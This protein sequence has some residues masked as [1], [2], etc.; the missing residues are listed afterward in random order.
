LPTVVGW[1]TLAHVEAPT[2]EPRPSTREVL[3]GATF[4]LVTGLLVA[5]PRYLHGPI[6]GDEGFLAA[7][8][9]RVLRGE[10]PNRDF[11]SLQPPFSFYAVA[12]GFA[13]FEPSLS[14]MRTIGLAL[15]QAVGLA[16]YAFALQFA[17]PAAAALAVAPIAVFGMALQKFVPFAVWFGLLWCSISAACL[18]SAF[19]PDPFPAAASAPTRRLLRVA[20][21]AITATLALLS[22]HDQGFYLCLASAVYLGLEVYA[23]RR[24]NGRAGAP[25]GPGANGRS[26]EDEAAPGANGRSTEDEAAPGANGRSTEDEAAPGANGRSTEDEAAPGANGRSA[27][28]RAAPRAYIL[29]LTWL[30]VLALSS[31][32]PLALWTLSGALAPAFEQLVIFPLKRYAETSALD[33]PRLGSGSPLLPTLFYYAPV[34]AA[35]SL[36]IGALRPA[37]RPEKTGPTSAAFVFAT[38]IVTLFYAQVATRTDLFHLVI[39]LP[40]CLVA[41]AAGF[42]TLQRRLAPMATT[43]TARAATWIP[44]AG[45]SA[46]IA[47]LAAPHFLTPLAPDARPLDLP[48]GGIWLEEFE[49][50]R[51]ERAARFAANR[52]PEEDSVLALPYQPVLNFLL[53]RRSP[54]RWLYLWPGDQTAEDHRELIREAES[55]APGLVVLDQPNRLRESAPEIVDWVERHYQSIA[56]VRA[57]VYFVPLET[58]AGP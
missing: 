6:W 58:A 32:L 28:D 22:R 34:P 35:L 2:P 24:A 48:R 21:A 13:F 1:E 50:Q 37:R 17:R 30:G 42:D 25:K 53:E 55:D 9:E 41:L 16:T 27:D 23:E 47:L 12:A 44:A 5:W 29:V 26:T 40:P 56:Q 3:T 14:V 20:T 52:V 43:P 18:I 4:V 46:G 33:W 36:G 31:A 38:L 45:L 49:A 51:Y 39:T 19:R 15:A 54:T 57:S 11:V 7:G 10:V 8:A